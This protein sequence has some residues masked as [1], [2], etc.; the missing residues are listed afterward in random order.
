[1]SL[2][3]RRAMKNKYV[4]V[5]QRVFNLSIRSRMNAEDMEYENIMNELWKIIREDLCDVGGKI[6]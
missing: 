2:C 4:E 5:L 3:K 6:K 1:M